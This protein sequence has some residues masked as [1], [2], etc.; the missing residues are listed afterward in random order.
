VATLLVIDV[1]ASTQTVSAGG[2]LRWRRLLS[3]HR[4]AVRRSLARFGGSEIDTAGDGFLAAFALPSSALHYVRDVILDAQAMG[5]PIRAGL[6]TGEVL[7]SPPNVIGIAV[8]VAARVAALAGPYEVLFTDT[9]KSL[10]LGSGITCEPAGE[11]ALKCGPGLWPLYRLT[12]PE[13]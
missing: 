5:I 12:S 6:H 3:A 2:D 7:I 8:H 10:V 1:V 4:D 11:Q 13:P 9:V